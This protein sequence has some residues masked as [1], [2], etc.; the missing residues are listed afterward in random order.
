MA[1]YK[2]TFVE[3]ELVRVPF[4][5]KTVSDAGVRTPFPMAGKK[6]SIRFRLRGATADL[7]FLDT[8]QAANE[9]GSVLRMADEAQAYWEVYVSEAQK[10]RFPKGF[11]EWEMHIVDA[12]GAPDLIAEGTFV[13]K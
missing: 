10:A 13:V 8:S 7:L 12:D 9:F 6:V 11:G 4:R 1:T 3:G 5:Y 2:F